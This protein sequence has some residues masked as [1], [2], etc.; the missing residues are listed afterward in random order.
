MVIIICLSFIL[1]NFVFWLG[2]SYSDSEIYFDLRNLETSR[3]QYLIGETV[4]VWVEVHNNGAQ[5]IEAYTLE[6]TFNLISP[7]SSQIY[8]DKKWNSFDIEPGKYDIIDVEWTI[9]QSAEGGFYDCQVVAVHKP[10]SLTKSQTFY[11][12]FEII[13]LPP[14]LDLVAEIYINGIFYSNGE[15]LN[16]GEDRLQVAFTVVNNGIEDAGPFSV[17][18]MFSGLG[19]KYAESLAYDGL[20]HGGIIKYEKT[21]SVYLNAKY[22][23]HLQ[24]DFLGQVREYNETNNNSVVF[25]QTCGYPK[26]PLR[27]EVTILSGDW[28]TPGSEFKVEIWHISSRVLEVLTSI[29]PQPYDDWVLTGFGL[30]EDTN[31]NGT[32]DIEDIKENMLK[33]LEDTALRNHL[34]NFIE[35]EYAIIPQEKIE[36][37]IDNVEK[38]LTQFG[39]DILNSVKE[40]GPTTL[41]DVKSVAVVFITSLT[42]ASGILVSTMTTGVGGIQIPIGPGTYVPISAIGNGLQNNNVAVLCPVDL[43]IIDPYGRVVNKTVNEIEGAIYEEKDLDGDGSLDDIITL[44]KGLINYRIYVIP[45]PTTSPNSMITILEISENM[46]LQVEK[47]SVSNASSKAYRLYLADTTPPIIEEVSRIPQYEIEPYQPV[48]VLAKVTDDNGI[49][50]VVLQ[51][52]VDKGTNWE[53]PTMEYNQTS[54]YYEATIPGQ[55]ANTEVKFKIIVYDETG[56]K[57]TTSETEQYYSYIVIPESQL[58]LTIWL[59]MLYIAVVVIFKRKSRKIRNA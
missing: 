34:K 44:P 32:I 37:V 49:A 11:N 56:N 8:V 23:A 18:Y 19:V 25:I 30:L 24:V 52:S 45:E 6:L 1:N 27:F 38:S 51:Y 26:I 59:L 35:T 4:D 42:I 13:V 40:Y 20:P 33:V 3:A 36:D 48:K 39:T 5:E 53:T 46:C 50:S 54:G 7:N 15:W 55:P 16:L 47:T 9:P 31:G 14:T 29:T 12:V 41:E 57:A 2:N 10:T 22:V 43:E 21:F 17:R 58:N 28:K